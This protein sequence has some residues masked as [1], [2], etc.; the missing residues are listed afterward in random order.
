[1]ELIGDM[2]R[3]AMWEWA[4]IV[5]GTHCVK[6]YSQ[7][8]EDRILARMYEGLVHG[9]YVD[10]GAYHPARFS[11][12]LLLYKRGWCGINIDAMPGRMRLFRWT[13]PRDV[14]IEA[15]V[16]DSSKELLYYM[17]NES[18]LNGF[19]RELSLSRHGQRGFRLVGKVRLKPRALGDIL[20][21][22]LRPGQDIHVLNIDVE[23]HEE[24]VLRSNNWDV[25]RPWLVLVESLGMTI[26]DVT[27][28]GAG[29]F[30]H[31]C[32]YKLKA[33]TRNTFF[34]ID[35]GRIADL[36]LCPAGVDV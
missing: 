30:L 18:A 23:G 34:F 31:Q 24:S 21:E 5:L 3:S 11:N 1:M 26:E 22:H 35:D 28:K 10:V 2:R 33:A 6:S 4:Q 16:S 32:G 13:R 29:A 17:F 15:A 25:F 27:R 20:S 14:N 12:T 8:G 36:G 7:E 9:F 19:S